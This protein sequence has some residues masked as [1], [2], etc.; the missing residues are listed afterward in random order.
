MN[1]RI[2]LSQALTGIKIQRENISAAKM[3]NKLFILLDSWWITSFSG[4]VIYGF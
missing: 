4:M 3:I 2:A 1:F